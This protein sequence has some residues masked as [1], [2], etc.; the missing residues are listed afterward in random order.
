MIPAAFEYSATHER[1]DALDLL[2][3]AERIGRVPGRRPIP[4]PLLKLRM[5]RPTA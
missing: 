4:L 5:L 2:P 1:R 3:P